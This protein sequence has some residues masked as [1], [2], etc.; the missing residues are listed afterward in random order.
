MFIGE[1]NGSKYKKTLLINLSEIDTFE[2][3]EEKIDEDS[4][5]YYLQ[6]NYKNHQKSQ[7]NINSSRNYLEKFLLNEKLNNINGFRRTKY[8]K[9]VQKYFNRIK[10][11][12]KH[13]K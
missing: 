7:I 5:T 12:F 10:R 1:V 2:L 3:L 8:R 9:H 13:N 11:K 4:F 6:I